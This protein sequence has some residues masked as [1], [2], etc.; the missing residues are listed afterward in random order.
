MWDKR[1]KLDTSRADGG[2]HDGDTIYAIRDAGEGI[3]I[4]NLD[5]L[6][7]YNVYAPELSQTGGQETRQFVV[8][9]L[10]REKAAVTTS[11]W[12]FIVTTVRMVRTDAEQRTLG[13]FVAVV[14]SMDG[15][16]NLNVDTQAF[17]TANGYGGGTGSTP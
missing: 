1:A 9:W 10:A 7:L 3:T 12:Y 6:R 8:D 13:R 11:G 17:I 4:N 5:G 16:R 15:S 2:V 14:T